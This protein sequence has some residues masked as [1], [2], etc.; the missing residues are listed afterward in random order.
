MIFDNPIHSL[1]AHLTLNNR[2]PHGLNRSL[3]AP[4]ERFVSA[5]I[6]ANHCNQPL[7][8]N[9]PARCSSKVSAKPSHAWL[10]VL[11]TA[12]AIKTHYNSRYSTASR[13]SSRTRTMCQS[14]LARWMLLLLAATLPAL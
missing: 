13:L 9:H 8:K 12:N 6:F 1:L 11:P 14:D 10:S 2:S 7:Y 3:I 5:T 4:V